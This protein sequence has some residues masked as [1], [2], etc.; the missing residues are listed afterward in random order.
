MDELEVTNQRNKKQPNQA[1]VWRN[2]V[3]F[4]Y[5]HLAAL[6]GLVLMFTSAKITTS[7]FGMSS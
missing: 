1:I 6:Y 5:L 2:V 4:S 7:V 3:L